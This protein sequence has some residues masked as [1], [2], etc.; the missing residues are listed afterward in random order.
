M[1][2]NDKQDHPISKEEWM[3]RLEEGSHVQRS[4]MNNLIM[5]YLVTGIILF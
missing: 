1:S 2:F 5:N 3:I 4:Q